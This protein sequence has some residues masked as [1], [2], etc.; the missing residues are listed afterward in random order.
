ME[1]IESILSQT[2]KNFE[3]IIIDD[4]SKDN[5]LAIIKKFQK[6][7]PKK[8]KLVQNKRN[9]NCGGDKC[10]NKGIL[11]AKGEYIARMDAD[12][13]CHPKRL[14]KQIAFLEKHPDVFLVGANAYVI[15]KKGKLIGEKLEPQDNQEIK[16]AYFTFHPLIHPSCTLRRI[17]NKKK[18]S[19][20]IK[21]SANNDYYTF[22]K[23]LCTGYKFANLKE[24]LLYF[25]IHGAN[26]TFINMREKYLNTLKARLT[27]VFKY[28][29]KPRVRDIGIAVMETVVVFLL[30]EKILTNIYLLAKGIKK[31]TLCF[32]NSF[33][34][35]SLFGKVKLAFSNLLA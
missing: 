13:I 3:L 9:L 11:L 12:D 24:K 25:R 23:L 31:P 19:Y 7:F 18:F 30:P 16:K 28:G 34:F 35:I 17:F 26:D 2:Y 10:A 5:S 1:A 14:E 8:I 21:Y 29:Y 33:G 22:F 6:R 27:M 20:E 32:K 4:A 15:N